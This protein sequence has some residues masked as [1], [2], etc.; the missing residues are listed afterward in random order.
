MHLERTKMSFVS[1][2]APERWHTRTL[3]RQYTIR[4]KKRHDQAPS[5][6]R[7]EFAKH[8]EATAEKMFWLGIG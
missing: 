1:V 3:L 5:E 7:D 2:W 4:V 8:G 6:I